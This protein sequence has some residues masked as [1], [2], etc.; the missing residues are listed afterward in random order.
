MLNETTMDILEDMHFRLLHI[1]HCLQGQE[2]PDYSRPNI[3]A[4]HEFVNK[5]IIYIRDAFHDGTLLAMSYADRV[6]KFSAMIRETPSI[7]KN[8]LVQIL[9]SNLSHESWMQELMTTDAF[10]K[11]DLDR[12]LYDI[13]EALREENVPNADDINDSSDIHFTPD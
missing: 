12:I 13:N 2:N 9:K 10:T 8:S 1:E 6:N 4:T 7:D 3:D 11:H 5:F